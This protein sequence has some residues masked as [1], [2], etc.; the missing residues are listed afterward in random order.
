MSYS[1]DMASNDAKINAETDCQPVAKNAFFARS[2]LKHYPKNRH[3][4]LQA[5]HPCM[6]NRYSEHHRLTNSV[7]TENH[8]HTDYQA[9]MGGPPEA[10]QTNRGKCSHHPNY[11]HSS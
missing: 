8:Q 1:T 5:G 3:G 11:H 6:V 9:A 2:F 4:P 7:S 10:G